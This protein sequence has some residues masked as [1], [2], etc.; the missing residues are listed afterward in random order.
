MGLNLTEYMPY[1]QTANIRGMLECDSISIGEGIGKE[2][3]IVLTQILPYQE[4]QEVIDHKNHIH[5]LDNLSKVL[6]VLGN[7]E[8]STHV[9]GGIGKEGLF[10]KRNSCIDWIG[11][12][13]GIIGNNYKSSTPNS[14]IEVENPCKLMAI[15]LLQ[16]NGKNLNIEDFA[17]KPISKK[18]NT[19]VIF[20]GA[21]SAEAGKT[22]L[23]CKIIKSLS[24]K[25]KKVAAIKT[26][27]SG[28]VMDCIQYKEAGAFIVLDQVDCGLITTY[29]NEDKFRKNIINGYLYAQDMN[30]DIIVAEMGGDII[31]ANNPTL[32]QMNEIIKNMMG[33]IIINNDALSLLGI[34]KYFQEQ[35]KN[36]LPLYYFASPF[37]NYYGMEKRAKKLTNTKL[38]DPNNIKM[39]DELINNL[40]KK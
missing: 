16:I 36:N 23:T 24:A 38:Y 37:R 20:V 21:T 19:P 33:L 15:G 14:F 13:S 31:W 3:D 8:S 18:L 12:R 29:T 4:I 5:L 28:G 39:I 34:Q 2:G 9:N 6:G 10:I 1:I 25:G 11:G 7:R 27:G 32:L 26:T 40:I 17:I 35:N 22:V 30:A